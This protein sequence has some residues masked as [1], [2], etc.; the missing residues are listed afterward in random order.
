MGI[1]R[2]LKTV[3]WTL[4]LFLKYMEVQNEDRGI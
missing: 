1:D 3:N 4:A 2:A